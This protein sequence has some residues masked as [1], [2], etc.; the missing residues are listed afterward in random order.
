MQSWA[1]NTT[2][3]WSPVSPATKEDNELVMCIQYHINKG[4]KVVGERGEEAVATELRHL[5]VQDE[6]DPRRPSELS[7]QEG[8]SALAY[9]MF[10]KEKRSWEAKGRN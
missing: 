1:A 3:L 8:A 9:F 5:P 7:T 10:L 6:L 4:L 2:R